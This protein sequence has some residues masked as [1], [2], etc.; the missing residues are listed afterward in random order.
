MPPCFHLSA[1]LLLCCSVVR[2]APGAVVFQSVEATFQSG[3]PGDLKN[4]ID[5]IESGP[6]GWSVAPRLGDRQAAI[7]RTAEPLEADLINVTLSFFSGQPNHAIAEFAFSATA[8]ATPS[9]AGHWEPM[10]VVRFKATN[11][12]LERMEGNRLR[13]VETLEVD[14]AARDVSYTVTVRTPLRGVTG[15]RL[16]AFPVRRASGDTSQRMAWSADGDFV[17]TEFRAEVVPGSTNV[18]LG[19]PVRTSHPVETYLTAEALT[20]GVPYSLVHPRDSNLGAAFFYEIDLGSVH[21]FDHLAL[22][23]RNDQWDIDRLSRVLIQLYDREPAPGV[24]PVWKTVHRA[25]GSHPDIASVDVLHAANGQ[26]VF[27][28]RYLRLSSD[29][30]VPKSPQLAEV[31]MYETRTP[32]LVSVRADGHGLAMGIPLFVPPGTHRLLLAMQILAAGLPPDQVFRWRLLGHRDEWQP[33][34]HLALDTPCPPAGTY[35]FEAQAAHSDGTWDATAL[36]VPITVR[37]PFIQTPAFRWLVAAAALLV[38]VLLSRHFTRRRIAALEARSALAD[39]RTRIARDMHDEVG[40]RLA[41]LAVLQ[42]VFASEYALPEAAQ[43]SIRQLSRTARQAVAS[44]DEVVWTVDPQNDTLASTAEYLARYATSYLA[45]LKIACRIVAPIDWPSA[46]IRAQVRHELILA[47]KEALQNVVKHAHA[48][49]VI[50]TLRHEPTWFIVRLA[51]NGCGLP[52]NAHGPGRDGLRNMAARLAAAGGI[53]EID[54]STGGAIVEMRV[55][56]PR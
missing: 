46:E 11:A 48:T 55:P 51:D 14:S 35:T 19:A 45:P 1:A 44:L 39:E 7:F 27:R 56:L 49:E 2:A 41:Q 4:T 12:T 23:Q 47:F 33:A 53:C 17:L 52:S 20:D 6:R 29:S 8:D 5:R 31:E 42:D 50:L 16:E 54:S 40:A 15:F 34:R 22:R 43:E 10:T 21:T 25:D 24:A 38:G 3:T 30:P 18:A 9:L 13:A 32:E 37:T 36:I 26:G 28:G